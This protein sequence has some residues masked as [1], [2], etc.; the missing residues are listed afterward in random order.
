M[1]AR[2]GIAVLDAEQPL[3]RQAVRGLVEERRQVVHPGAERDALRPGAELHVLLDAGV[4][5]ADDRPQLGHG[6]AVQGQDQPEHAVRGRVLRAHVDH[7]ALVARA[8]TRLVGGGDHLV[9]VLPADVVDAPLGLVRLGGSRVR[10]P[11]VRWRHGG[12]AVLD[13]DAAERVILALRVALPVVGHLDPGQRRVPVE[14]D[15]EEVPGLPLV[16]V[17]GRVDAHQR[18]HVRVG[19]RRRSPRAGAPVVGDRQQV[20]DGVQL[21]AGIGGVVHAGDPGAQ[22]EGERGL[23]PQQPRHLE[24]VLP[25][26]VEG[27][28]A[29]VHDHPLDGVAEA[30][31]RLLERARPARRRPR[32]STTRTAAGWTAPGPAG[33]AGPP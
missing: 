24:Q 20:V 13:R 6:L 29:A 5:V 18:R 31:S 11:L 30:R 10:P 16:P 22:L 19:V 12:A 17:T 15:P 9:P 7:E 14:D 32:R 27:Q 4:Q 1:L 21:A 26:D 3:H 8:V 23:V 33:P 25:P 28:F 2:S